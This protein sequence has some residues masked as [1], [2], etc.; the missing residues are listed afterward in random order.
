MKSQWTPSIWCQIEMRSKQ[1]DRDISTQQLFS[2][3]LLFD[4]SFMK[5]LRTDSP[6][7]CL[8]VRDISVFAR[9]KETVPDHTVLSTMQEIRSQIL[10]KRTVPSRGKALKPTYSTC[11]FTFDEDNILFKDNRNLILKRNR[12]SKVT[13]YSTPDWYFHAWMYSRSMLK[14]HFKINLMG[15]LI[16]HDTVPIIFKTEWVI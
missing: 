16:L 1:N 4:L 10:I 8:E 3:W 5:I 15:W 14:N 7:K 12:K 9:I 13:P 2:L 11:S 6:L